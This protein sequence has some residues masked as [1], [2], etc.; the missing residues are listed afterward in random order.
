MNTPGESL[1]LG[2]A[3]LLVTADFDPDSEAGINQW[4]NEEHVPERVL[5]P[6]FIW[7][8][9]YV[10]V[11]GTP[12]YAN[13]YGLESADVL[14]SEPYLALRERSDWYKRTVAGHM[15]T[16]RSVYTDITPQIPDGYQVRK[17]SR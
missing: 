11:E 16:T 1:E 2:K 10:N 12:K 9:R 14:N 17:L 5:C 8:R 7:A 6:G 13:L 3:L 4:F 15:K